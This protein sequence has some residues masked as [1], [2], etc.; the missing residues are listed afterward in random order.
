MPWV[1]KLIKEPKLKGGF[2]YLVGHY[3]HVTSVQENSK[4]VAIYDLDG[5]HTTGSKDWSREHFDKPIWVDS[6]TSDT[7]A[8][9]LI[10]DAKKRL[11]E[12]KPNIS[13]AN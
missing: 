1:A 7:V 4:L 13:W 11:E 5:S 3:Y 9:L 6:Y 10:Q 12:D 2:N 8:D